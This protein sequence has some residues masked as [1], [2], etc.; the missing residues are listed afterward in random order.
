MAFFFPTD[1]AIR[2]RLPYAYESLREL[3]GK[4]PIFGICLGHQV[5]GLALAARPSN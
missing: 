2:Q 5:L 4:K 1:Q 3:M